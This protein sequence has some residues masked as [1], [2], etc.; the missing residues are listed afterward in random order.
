MIIIRNAIILV[1]I[2]IL[3]A[4]C[5][6]VQERKA[7]SDWND[8]ALRWKRGDVEG[9]NLPEINENTTL[10]DYV[11]YAMLNNPGLR[12]AFDRWQAALE[13]VTPARTLP[14]PHFTYAN[15]IQEVET[16]VG[17]QE[18]KFGL[19]QTVPWFGKLDLKADMALQAAQVERLRYEAEKLSLIYRVK[20]IYYEY[21]YLAQAVDIAKD[22]VTLLTHFESVVRAKYKGGA[23]LQ[24]A[25]IK[26]QVELGKLEDRLRS[27][28]DLKRP[29][30]AKLNIAL[31]RSSYMLLPEPNGLPEEKHNLNDE[32]LFTLLR[33]RNPNLKAFDFMA[34]KEDLA[35][36][37][38][39][40]N[41]YPDVTVGVDYIDTDSRSDMNPE[42]NGKDPVIAK[43]TVNVPIWHQKYSA[44]E[45]EAKSRRRAV[46]KERNEKI[47][48][49]IADIEMA[50]YKLRDADRKINLYAAT[51]VP[52]AEQNVKV[53]QRAFTSDK[54]GFLDLIDS[55]RILLGFQLESKRA[56]ADRAQRI[57]E[58]E[59]LVGGDLERKDPGPEGLILEK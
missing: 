28:Q 19:A 32:E 11:I 46:Q 22:N 50:L 54:A 9:V 55:Q 23:G 51:L 40:K 58:I 8:E 56:L 10:D 17:A 7:I 20:K 41:F 18:Q 12:A 25:L 49:L 30:K 59:M 44:M 38:A 33:T 43:V 13:R 42:D 48:S 31:N 45:N 47:N 53:T 4:A 21:C 14:D 3:A 2:L 36:K 24:S 29:V 26:A 1:S 6:T 37:L 27:L 57:A 15:Y 34:T 5:T 35:I 39:E 16:R 52:K